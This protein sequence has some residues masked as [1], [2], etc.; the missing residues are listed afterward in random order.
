MTCHYGAAK[1]KQ[2]GSVK[3]NLSWAV[4][5]HI[6]TCFFPPDIGFL[7]FTAIYVLSIQGGTLAKAVRASPLFRLVRARSSVG[8]ASD[9]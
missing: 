9:F 5:N 2:N 3:H 8:R 6:L 7:G 4:K 1:T